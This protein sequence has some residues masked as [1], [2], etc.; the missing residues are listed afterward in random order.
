MDKAGNVISALGFYRYHIAAIPD[1]DDRLPKEFAVSR[2]RNNLLQAVPDLGRLDPHV[3]ANIRQGR[4]GII[5][6]LFF[7]QDRAENSILQV[8][9]GRQGVEK[10]GKNGLFLV[11]GN[12]AFDGSGAAKDTGNAQQFLRLQA[13]APV[14]P[15][16]RCGNVL[17]IGKAGIAFFCAEIGCRSGLR[18][19]RPDL[20]QIGNRV[21]LGAAGLSLAAAGAIRQQPQNLV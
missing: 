9:I 1:G 15:L 20:L 7:R 4:A 6:D 5:C 11:F 12:V 2:R 13:A 21:Q 16:Q 8:F 19:Q 18:Q 17:Y 3:P 14:R 10:R